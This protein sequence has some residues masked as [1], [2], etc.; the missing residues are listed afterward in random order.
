VRGYE[1]ANLPGG[2]RL[3]ARVEHRYT[4]G[5]VRR[6]GDVGFAAFAD[7]GQQWA[8][9]V[10]FGVT[11]P[12]KSSIGFSLLA[13]VPRR[14]ARMW[15]ADFAVPLNKGAG[16]GITVRFTN[17]DRTAFVF[18]DARDVAKGRELTMPS[19]IFAWP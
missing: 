5:S 16:A 19:S 7:A 10:P 17:T 8:G 12:V 6:M 13:A 11:T 1:N 9:D 2:Q 4:Y 14:S 3:V 15:R 18:R